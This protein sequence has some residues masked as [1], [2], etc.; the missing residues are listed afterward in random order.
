MLAVPDADAQLVLDVV[1]VFALDQ[2]DLA[3]VAVA[4][5]E[6]R[7]LAVAVTLDAAPLD[8]PDLLDA[9]H[10][11]AAFSGN[12]D[13]LDNTLHPCSLLVR[14]LLQQLAMG[15]N[16]IA[17]ISAS[18]Q[19]SISALVLAEVL[20][21]ANSRGLDLCYS[22]LVAETSLSTNTSY[23]VRPITIGSASLTV[24]PAKAGIHVP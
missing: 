18:Q 6:P 15:L 11:R 4:R 20:K 12:E 9:L 7:P 2:G 21:C 1:E 5:P 3:H 24:I 23:Q 16:P 22:L 19:V 8:G 17:S 10:R 14:S 13:P